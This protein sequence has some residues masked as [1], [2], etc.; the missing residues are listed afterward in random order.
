MTVPPGGHHWTPEQPHQQLHHCPRRKC[1]QT[2][3]CSSSCRWE[4]C[5]C[6]GTG[7]YIFSVQRLGMLSELSVFLAEEPCVASIHPEGS[8][9]SKFS[10][11]VWQPCSSTVTSCKLCPKTVMMGSNSSLIFS[12]GIY[13]R[14]FL[15]IV[16]KIN[17]AIFNPTSRN[18]KDRRQSI[19]LLDIFGFENFSNNR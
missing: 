5:L 3:Q 13:G 6:E 18:P 15:W 17:S 2:S 9:P 8:S 10:G 1:I 4:G 16:N 12:Q 19:G 7:A 14:I 11:I